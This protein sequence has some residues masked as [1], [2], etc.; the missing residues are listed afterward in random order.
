MRGKIVLTGIGLALTISLTIVGLA[1]MYTPPANALKIVC[2]H[3]HC[4]I[5]R[6]L[7]P[8]NCTIHRI[9]EV[10]CGGE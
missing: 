5:F 8:I 7:P 1:A 9:P 2:A 6:E 10:D 3:F 4:H